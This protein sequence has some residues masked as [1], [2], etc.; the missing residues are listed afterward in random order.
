VVAVELVFEVESIGWPWTFYFTA[1][2]C[3]A[4]LPAII[5]FVPET[6]YRRSAS[7][8]TDFASS[9]DVRLHTKQFEPAEH[10]NQ[11]KNE[12]PVAEPTSNTVEA[13]AEAEK[14][15]EGATNG[16]SSTD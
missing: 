2:F 14:Q 15:T 9:E 5:F 13:H 6:A 10:Q 3:G 1:I 11:R 8:N 4:C 7:L 16:D 12:G